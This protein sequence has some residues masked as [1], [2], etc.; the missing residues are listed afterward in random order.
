MSTF[1][2]S[3]ETLAEK[4]NAGDEEPGL[5]AGDRSL[6]VFGKA[7]IAPDPGKGTFD[8]PAFALRFEGS[9]PLGSGD[10]LDLPP[11]EFG[12]GLAQLTA[13]VDPIGEDVAQLWECGS[14]RAK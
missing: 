5:C 14:Q 13:A 6:E 10:N 9:D 2:G 12:S 4:A 1:S 11:A 3:G 8:D 7:A